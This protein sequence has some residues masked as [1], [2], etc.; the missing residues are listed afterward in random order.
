M[1]NVGLSTDDL[2]SKKSY[3]GELA[4]SQTKRAEVELTSKWAKL[5][6]SVNFYSMH[7]GWS[8]TPGVQKSLPSFFA[9]MESRLRTP[10]Q[11]ADTIVWA[12]ASQ[13]VISIPNGSFLFGT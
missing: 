13:E 2:E 6:P 8:H 7:P 3:S 11:G 12:A 9:A 10:E 4:Y 5:Y 1:Y